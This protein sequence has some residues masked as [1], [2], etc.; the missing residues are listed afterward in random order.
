MYV[1]SCRASERVMASVSRFLTKKLRLK[2]NEAK[3]AVARQEERKFL[4]F[5]IS[6]AAHRAKSSRQI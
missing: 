2:V 5:S 1:R 6:N 4:G 3:S